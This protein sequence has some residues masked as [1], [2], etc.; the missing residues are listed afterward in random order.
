MRFKRTDWFLH[1]IVGKLNVI[2]KKNLWWKNSDCFCKPVKNYNLSFWDT[3]PQK[4]Y[5]WSAKK[6]CILV[7]DK[8][9]KNVYT[10]ESL[11]TMVLCTQCINHSQHCT[12]GLGNVH[13][14]STY[15]NNKVNFKKITKPIR[16]FQLT[17]GVN[18]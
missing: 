5:I 3:Y 8:T 7:K 15:T 1:C 12:H 11:C 10:S 9:Y 6:D 16:Y 4:G 2:K 13:K 14:Y 17:F 18:S